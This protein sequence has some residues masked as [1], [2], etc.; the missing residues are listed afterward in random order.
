[1]IPFLLLVS[2]FLLGCAYLLLRGVWLGHRQQRAEQKQTNVEIARSRLAVITSARTSG[3]ISE[4]EFNNERSVIEQQLANELSRDELSGGRSVT[5]GGQ[6][7]GWAVIPFFV[8]GVAWLYLQ[9]GDP[10][11]LDSEF[12]ASMTASDSSIQANANNSGGSATGPATASATTSAADLV[13]ADGKLPSIEELLPRLE[14]HLETTP[15]DSDGWTLL[16]TTYMRLRRFKDAELALGKASELLPDDNRILLQLADAKAMLTDGSIGDD[17]LSLIQR[18]LQTEPNNVQANWLNGMA[19]QQRGDSR[20]AVAAW[21]KLLPQV[22][23]DPRSSQQLQQMIAEARAQIGAGQETPLATERT[24]E[25]AESATS[26]TEAGPAIEVTVSIGSQMVAQLENELGADAAPATPVFIYAR[27]TQ[28]PPMPLAVVRKTLAD[29]PLTVRLDD[30]MA[31]MPNLTLS[32]FASAGV[33][34][35]ARV[36]LAGNPIAQPGDAYGEQAGLE[37]SDEAAITAVSIEITQRVE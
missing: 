13:G 29:L 20:T 16:G 26:S 32:S 22:A 35:G 25:A 34:I 23:G 8:A 3:E 24:E 33:T 1:M 5:G 28:G 15:D 6:W 7:L 17:A 27:A 19:A 10:R 37:V 11:A 14:A 2:V 18:V 31:M 21:E 30:S 4:E 36:S 9:L 12:V